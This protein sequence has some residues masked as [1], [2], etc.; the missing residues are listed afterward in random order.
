MNALVNGKIL[1]PDGERTG[2]ALLFSER[3]IGLCPESEAPARADA[4]IDAGGLYI[5]PGLI[6]THIH[7]FQ[8]WDVSDASEAGV[9]KM[10]KALLQTGVT[11]FLP[12]TTALP[13]PLLQTIFAQLR[14]LRAESRAPGFDGAEIL[15]CHAEGPFLNPEKKGAQRADCLLPP[16]AEKLLPYADI[17]TLLTLAPELPGGLDCVRTLKE[18]TPIRLSMGHTAA[19]Y[20]LAMEAIS[21]GVC[22]ATHVFNAMP[23]LLHRAPGAAGAALS[24]PIYAEI[25]ADTVHVHPA[26]LA[27]AAKVKGDQ[28]VLISD[29]TRAGGLPIGRYTL[30]GQ[31]IDVSGGACRLKDGTLAGSVLKLTDA[32]GNMRRF[33]GLSMAQAVRLASL[34]PAASL[35]LNGRKGCLLP[36]RDADIIL[37]D[38]AL[39]VS[40]VFTRGIR[41]K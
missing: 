18:K 40:A 14:R 21:R 13:W 12:T 3:I 9:L 23:P 31:E 26:M 34:S 22:R 5:S 10:A 27:L 33:A 2:Q 25:I 38:D 36:G 8:G 39:H 37:L 7:G 6:D 29:C 28:L 30:G 24:A 41:Q 16:D 19:D 20:D 4:V 17:V 1:M 11:A 15:G 35:G 32:V